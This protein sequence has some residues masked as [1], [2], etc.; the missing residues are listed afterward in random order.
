MR[1]VV[2]GGVA[3]GMSAASQARRRDPGCEVVVLERGRDISYSACGMPYNIG[4][5][6]RGV[7]DL[8]ILNAQDF[9]GSPAASITIPHRIPPGFHG[10]WVAMG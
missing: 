3:A 5:P 9:T 1:I 10:N 7:D 4:D 8:V 6:A 2:I